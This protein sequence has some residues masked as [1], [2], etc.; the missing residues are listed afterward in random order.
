ML[1]KRILKWPRKK[2]KELDPWRKR[3]PVEK[4]CTEHGQIYYLDR[5]ET[6]AV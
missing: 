6:T 3:G 5:S 2:L 1:Y 4:L